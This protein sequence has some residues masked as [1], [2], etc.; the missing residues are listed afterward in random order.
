MITGYP[1][2]YDNDLGSPADIHTS[3]RNSTYTQE[4]SLPRSNTYTKHARFFFAVKPSR[5]KTGSD[6]HAAR[7]SAR[8]D[9]AG[10]HRTH[11]ALAPPPRDSERTSR[12]RVRRQVREPASALDRQARPRRLC[13]TRY[14][15][16]PCA[17]PLG[18]GG[19]TGSPRRRG[20]RLLRLP[21]QLRC[22]LWRRCSGPRYHRRKQQ[23][24]LPPLEIRL[25]QNSRAGGSRYC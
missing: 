12:R 25:R 15:S 6:A 23:H 3:T 24:P 14:P 17:P 18:P 4:I 9:S 5:L 10:S 8:R 11:N 1:A 13:E 2:A 20:P 19:R 16:L 21:H 22:R 7:R